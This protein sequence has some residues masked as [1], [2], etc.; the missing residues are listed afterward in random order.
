[1]S[2]RRLGQSA[3]GASTGG[4]GSAPPA[5]STP[6]EL[7]TLEAA[8]AQ[9]TESLARRVRRRNGRVAPSEVAELQA[10]ATLVAMDRRRRG[11]P[12]RSR[13]PP[14]LMGVISLLLLSLLLFQRTT[15]TPV[16]LDMGVTALQFVSTTEQAITRTLPLFALRG[17]GLQHDEGGV[18]APVLAWNA[19]DGACGATLTLEPLVLPAGSRV[20]LRSAPGATRVHLSLLAPGAR[21]HVSQTGCTSGQSARQ[22]RER[23]LSLGDEE[24]D[25]EIQVP[26][27]SRIAFAPA[28][29]A[30]AIAF[31]EVEQL[32]GD[33]RTHVRLVSTVREGRVR[34]PALGGKEWPLRR[35]E[36]LDLTRTR[37]DLRE[38]E[39]GAGMLTLRY[40]GEVSGLARGDAPHAQ[41]LMPTWLEWL[42]ANQSLSLLWGS[43]FYLVG[44]SMAVWR[45]WR[46]SAGSA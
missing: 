31:D 13:L 24:V 30:S 6:G 33:D 28:I 23:V 25:L 2:R 42:R 36:R 7:P 27:G 4:V 26:E 43:L 12:W 21:L 14:L 3:D 19:D 34:L 11:D 37:G 16:E 46:S 20:G 22:V 18:A 35:G 10:L 40:S 45:W 5:R 17:A 29:G 1:V 9:R 38:L 8:L 44:L 32:A 41:N 15:R 39:A